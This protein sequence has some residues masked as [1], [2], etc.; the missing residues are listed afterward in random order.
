[1]R[2]HLEISVLPLHKDAADLEERGLLFQAPT[3]AM[4]LSSGMGK[5]WPEAGGF[6]A[7]QLRR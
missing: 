2:A 6:P 5:H 4:L 3:S 7:R 1:M